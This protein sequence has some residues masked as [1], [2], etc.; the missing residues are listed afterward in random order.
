MLSEIE[1]DSLSDILFN[2]DLANSFAEG[3]DYERFQVDMR[4]F[5]PSRGASKLFPKPHAGYLP[6]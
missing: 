3:F 6:K 2:I 1:R 5:M 4:T